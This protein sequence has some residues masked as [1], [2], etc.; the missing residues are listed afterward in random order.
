VLHADGGAVKLSLIDL[1]RGHLRL[2]SLMLR[3]AE[4]TIERDAAG[5][6]RVLGR[7]LP[8]VSGASGTSVLPHGELELQ[9]AV[10]IVSD[11]RA[12][13]CA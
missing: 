7:E 2:G 1:L 3:G 11:G 5:D 12:H 10:V 4:I 9:D 8:A 6:W 13:R